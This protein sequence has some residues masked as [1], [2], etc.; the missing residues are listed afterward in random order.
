MSFSS[1]VKNELS[2]VVMHDE[3]CKMAELTGF[4]ITNCSI[5]KENGDFILRM[6]TENASAIRRVY[7]AFKSLYNI[8]PITNIE[9]EKTFKDNLYQL[10][11][12]DKSDLEKI[13]KNSY[14]N[15]D[16]RLQIIIDDKGKILEKE[17]CKRSFLRGVFMGGGSM[18]D[19]NQMYHLEVVASNMENA[20]FINR[21]MNDMELN[22]KTIKRKKEFVVYIKGAERISDLL[23]SIGSNKGILNFEQVRV[24]KEVKNRVNR[25]NNFENANL[26]KTI[27]TAI[28]QIED[29][30]II[31]KNRKFQK[32]PE[33]LK[34]IALLR[35]ENKNDTY[36]ELGEKL[37]P[38]LSRAGV[39]HRF[40]KIKE[41]ADELRKNK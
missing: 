4:L 27:D 7:N 40:K 3:C 1:E 12:V 20:T 33:P 41:I 14:I 19:P 22:A 28:L 13:F 2:H 8:I 5:T 11:I 16:T 18:A 35:L 6:S 21:I 32:L 39:S 23:A 15:I 29:I 10:K 37:N 36:T 25:I 34:E 9:K 24:I 38:P 30:M 17:C 31:R 26:E